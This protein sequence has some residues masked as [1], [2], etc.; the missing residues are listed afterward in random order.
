DI[1]GWVWLDD[2][3]RDLRYA[4][5]SVLR[6][7]TLAA[8]VTAS[9]G[10]GIGVNTAVF[11][12]IQMV[13]LQPIPGVKNASSFYLVEPKSNVGAYP[14]SSWPEYDDLR[15]RLTSFR[16]LIAFRSAPLSV[17]EADQTVRRYALL[18]SDNYFSGLGL[19]PI[20]GRLF[21]ANEA[22]ERRPVAVLSYSY[23]KGQFN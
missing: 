7:K 21:D 8:V 22:A 9:L 17:G 19:Q 16:E 6:M 14:N 23:W 4:F 13:V 18:V 5:R 3:I 2:A 12:W 10:I 11:S 20:L 15:R 1:W